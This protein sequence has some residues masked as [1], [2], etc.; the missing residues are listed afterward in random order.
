MNEI[1]KY[2]KQ[3]LTWD[4]KP[5]RNTEDEVV[6]ILAPMFAM[7]AA[8][9]VDGNTVDAYVMMLRNVDPA[10]LRPAVLK[11]MDT[12]KFLPTVAEIREYIAANVLPGPNASTPKAQMEKPIP[13][14]MFR[15]DPE[16]DKKQ[17]MAQLKRTRGWN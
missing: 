3:E 1:D 11:A 16:E 5:V 2:Q 10:V 9:K 12:C 6:A 8:T 15:L 14:K 4:N 7:F 17:R 13:Q